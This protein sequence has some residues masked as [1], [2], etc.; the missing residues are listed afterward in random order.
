MLAHSDIG[1][2]HEIVGEVSVHPRYED[3]ISGIELEPEAH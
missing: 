3:A 1:F 2:S